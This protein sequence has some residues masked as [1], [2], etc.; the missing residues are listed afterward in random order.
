MGRRLPEPRRT[1]GDRWPRRW[2]AYERYRVVHESSLEGLIAEGVVTV[3]GTRFIE[4]QTLDGLARVDLIGHIET[5]SGGI[6]HVSKRLAVRRRYGRWHVLTALYNYHARVVRNGGFV[7][8]FRYDNAHGD[9]GTLH[10]HIYDSDGTEIGEEPVR[11][12]ELPPLSRIVRDV[13]FYAHY[14]RGD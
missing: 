3:D 11:L 14:L 1:Q 5:A 13:E 2:I 8:V 9:A 7:D 6:L 12:D 10:R 4:T